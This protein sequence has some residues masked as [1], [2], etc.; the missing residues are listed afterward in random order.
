MDARTLI[1]V[2]LA[3]LAAVHLNGCGSTAPAPL[4]VTEA[5]VDQA[6]R[7]I[8]R[9][10]G[11]ELE[12]IVDYQFAAASLGEEW[13]ILNVAVAG[14]QAAA[15]EVRSDSIFLR[16]PNGV[17]IPL[18]S[19]EAFAAAFSEVQ[20]ASRRAALAASPLDFTR[21]DRRWCALAFHPLP[22]SAMVATSVHVTMRRLCSG[23]LYFKIPGGIQPGRYALMIELEE[24]E[25]SVPFL[26]EPLP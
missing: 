8:S 4:Q 22:G 17:R 11:P 1:P 7:Y 6:G 19:Y 14:T 18:P 16:T 9:Y 26:I 10:R 5:S 13:M 25:V 12:T 23:P 20:S 15:T 3:T 21:A 24:S 2:A